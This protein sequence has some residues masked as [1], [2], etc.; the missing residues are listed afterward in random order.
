MISVLRESGVT[1]TLRRTHYVTV[2]AGRSI[3]SSSTP[4]STPSY[5]VMSECV[6]GWVKLLSKSSLQGRTSVSA[7]NRQGGHA[8]AVPGLQVVRAVAATTDEQNSRRFTVPACTANPLQHEPSGV[9]HRTLAR[10]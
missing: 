6:P 5:F 4:D 10:R 1:E 7:A 9:R 3:Q 2:K 8:P